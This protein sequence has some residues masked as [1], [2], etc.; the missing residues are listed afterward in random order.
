[1]IRNLIVST[2]RVQFSFHG[3]YALEYTDTFHSKEL[4]KN[5]FSRKQ[6]DLHGFAHNRTLP[7]RFS[8]SLE[9]NA[10]KLDYICSS[11]CKEQIMKSLFSNEKLCD[12]D[13]MH[14]A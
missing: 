9:K 4:N 1:M 13:G 12:I 8:E 2:G 6:F 11:F 7:R 5:I 3:K 10:Y 14:N